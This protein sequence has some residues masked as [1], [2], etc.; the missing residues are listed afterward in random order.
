MNEISG[1]FAHLTGTNNAP[2][3]GT[4][5][6]PDMRREEHLDAQS[7]YVYI[8]N[9]PVNASDVSDLRNQETH[10][11]QLREWDLRERDAKDREL[12]EGDVRNR[13]REER[14]DREKGRDPRNREH[15]RDMR[16]RERDMNARVVTRAR[17]EPAIHKSRRAGEEAQALKGEQK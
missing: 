8:Y 9:A 1:T 4:S 3:N 7:I 16:K 11:R 12:R 14:N 17:D 6:K 13:E 2:V 10:A 5:R 15:P